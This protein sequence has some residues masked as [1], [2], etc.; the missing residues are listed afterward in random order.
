[1]MII[2]HCKAYPFAVVVR[3]VVIP[4]WRI[5]GLLFLQQERWIN[6]TKN[7][8][9][10]KFVTPTFQIDMTTTQSISKAYPLAI[11]VEEVETVI[12]K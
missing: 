11:P 4:L 5:A 10:N 6:N 7:F 3:T 1:M 12:V 2:G 9:Y 8:R